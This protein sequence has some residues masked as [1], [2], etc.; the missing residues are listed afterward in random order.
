M[1]DV[2]VGTPDV[3]CLVQTGQEGI[4]PLPARLPARRA[5]QAAAD[6]EFLSWAVIT[7]QG[8]LYL[9]VWFCCDCFVLLPSSFATH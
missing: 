5:L 7:D 2:S 6:C 3:F 8:V 4:S 9:K 1:L